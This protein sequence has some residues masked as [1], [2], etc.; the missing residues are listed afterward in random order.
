MINNQQPRRLQYGKRAYNSEP[1]Q[2]EQQLESPPMSDHSGGAAASY[3]MRPHGD[4]YNNA[5]LGATSTAPAPAMTQGS[6]HRSCLEW[7]LSHGGPRSNKRSRMPPAATYYSSRSRRED[8]GQDAGRDHAATH[9]LYTNSAAVL[10][11]PSVLARK[12]VLMRTKPIAAGEGVNGTQLGQSG[13]L[14]IASILSRGPTKLCK[15]AIVPR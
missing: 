11:Y 14:I 8:V 4:Q 10:R 6:R 9:H 1:M 5:Y 13:A 3:E 2:P 7:P 15:G 12:Y